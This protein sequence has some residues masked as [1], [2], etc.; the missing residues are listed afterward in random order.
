[1]APHLAIPD[2]L[3]RGRF[4]VLEVLGAG[5]FG[6]VLRCADEA[7]RGAE[8]ALKLLR[9]EAA[10]ARLMFKREFRSL[11]DISHPS[12]VRLYELFAEADPWFFTMELLSGVTAAGFV[13]G[14]S[15][16]ATA[17]QVTALA[18][19][20]RDPTS[21]P[22]TARP[23]RAGDPDRVRRVLEGMTEGLLHLHARGKLHRD[24]KPTNV[25]VTDDR[26]VLLD[27][28][29]VADADETPDGRVV[30][31][32]L[33]MSPEQILGGDTGP[34]SDFYSLGVTA[35]EL[36]TG[37]APHAAPTLAG[38]VAQKS[39]EDPAPPSA[40]SPGVEPALEALCLD[41]LRRA[42]A[43]RPGGEEILA[44]LRG[45]DDPRPR[46]ARA[47][48]LARS[49]L[50]GRVAERV[51]IEEAAARAHAERRLV[52]ATL[53]G[54][55]GMGKSTLL[56]A[57][58]DAFAR[59]HPTSFVL[60][61]RC[62]E[63]ESVPF[64]AL[65]G[66]IDALS[67]ALAALPPAT[68]EGLAPANAGA[69]LAMFPVLA[70]V[71]VLRDAAGGSGRGSPTD[72]RHL[73]VR[74]LAELL[75]SLAALGPVVVAID[76]LQWGDDDSVGALAELVRDRRL[77][78][79]VVTAHREEEETSPF[80]AATL[81]VLYAATRDRL[82]VRLGPLSQGD[83]RLLV[84]ALSPDTGESAR[85]A[86]VT[87]AAGR[88]F[89]LAELSHAGATT[90]AGGLEAALLA[91]VARLPEVARQL[92][93]VLAIAGRPLARDVLEATAPLD[94]DVPGALRALS[95]E[96]LV[97][98]GG[99]RAASE[100]EMF[101]DS[102][103]EAVAAALSPDERRAA[104]LGLAD[105]MERLAVAGWE[106]L[107]SHLLYAG[108]PERAVRYAAIAAEEAAEAHAFERSAELLRVALDAAS[109]DDP[110]RPRWCRQRA[111]ALTNAGR[112][113]E[114]AEAWLVAAGTARTPIEALDHE[115]RAAERFLVTG[116]LDRGLELLRAL[117]SRAGLW[118]PSPALGLLGLAALR[119]VIVVRGLTLRARSA[120]TP[121]ALARVDIAWTVASGLAL[122]DTVRG[123]YFSSLHTL[124]ALRA[125]DR[126]RIVRALATEVGFESAQ[127]GVA[128]R[129][130][131]VRALARARELAETPYEQAT[132]TLQDGVSRLLRCDFRGGQPLVIEAERELHD[133]CP[134]TTWERNT[135]RLFMMVTHRVQGTWGELG[136][137]FEAFRADARE[138][139]DRYAETTFTLAVGF[140]PR[141]ADGD[142][143][144]AEEEAAE[145]R[146]AWDGRGFLLQH[147]YALVGATHIALYRERGRGLCAWA[148]QERDWPRFRA[149][150]L[151]VVEYVRLELHLL[152][153]AAAIAG[154]PERPDLA[155]AA[156]SALRHVR[157]ARIPWAM[158][159]AELHAASLAR[160]TGDPRALSRLRESVVALDRCELLAHA[161][162]ARVVWGEQTGGD[163][164]RELAAR[165][166]A[167]FE[168]QRV[169][170]VD[171]CVAVYT[172]GAWR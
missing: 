165:G 125:G 171:A 51:S 36:L 74:A 73:G 151:G 129:R 11:A 162:A 100:L 93:S 84:A 30:G 24:V 137:I 152:R 98:A 70:R 156:R 145:A 138:R 31:T 29:L 155:A 50:V 92:L 120:A 4:R 108:R 6:T 76:D 140:A 116:H 21:A 20:E 163:E 110:A 164:G 113:A 59:R 111:E 5:G 94:A 166:R 128:P 44:R 56:A 47:P 67:L 149:S 18:P 147:H 99:D 119:V 19:T 136:P 75:S 49:A 118:Y 91:R 103:R 134:G 107:A 39:M 58:L 131:E 42:P 88:P 72:A 86:I 168:D 53:S 95:V 143:D 85:D 78:A 2:T 8:V 80:L 159:W 81:P 41:L 122:V 127:G 23:G 89:L 101:H 17:S 161:A 34:E 158:A 150:Q 132:V 117:L 46:A 27:F 135:A 87:A 28:G 25:M 154:V 83:A 157:R 71:P 64:A 22:A 60:A 35:Y 104:H 102:I 48:R 105:A 139:G 15:A 61:G 52:V 112:G 153:A 57:A 33:Y 169:A 68:L 97:R 77:P 130:L 16:A 115:R 69:L 121:E 82:D 1:M 126:G 142:P 43:D 7:R 65:D 37:A 133:R 32:P 10:D 141:L 124:L 13:R 109:P 106:A 90:T 3:A 40:L 55:S 63:Q 170:D 160:A 38:L 114:S 9:L 96:R 172:P 26:V 123:A 146:A 54:V 45:G 167:F 144:T 62:Y 79:L 66:V 14:E 148:E 12:L